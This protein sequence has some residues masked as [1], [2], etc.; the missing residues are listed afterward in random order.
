MEERKGSQEA[1]VSSSSERWGWPGSSGG[2]EERGRQTQGI[3]E[4]K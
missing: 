4:L 1:P 2:E 3:I